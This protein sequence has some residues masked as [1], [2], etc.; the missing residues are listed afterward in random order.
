MFVVVV[1]VVLLLLLSPGESSSRRAMSLLLCL[2]DVFRA[3][4]NSIVC[5]FC[6]CL[7]LFLGLFVS[8]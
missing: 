7:F 6:P 5:S 1:V 3:L 4:I 8:G 2:C